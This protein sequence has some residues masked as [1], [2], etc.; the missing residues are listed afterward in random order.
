MERVWLEIADQRQ[1]EWLRDIT[2][3]G[4]RML[5]NGRLHRDFITGMVKF[6]ATNGT[7]KKA[8]K[9]I[10]EAITLNKIKL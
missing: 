2:E 8:A 9:A 4:A 1:K 5:W 10:M 3:G 7:A 6:G